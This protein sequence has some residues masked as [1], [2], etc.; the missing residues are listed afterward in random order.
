MTLALM[1]KGIREMDKD[2]KVVASGYRKIAID[3]ANDI[4]GGKYKEGQKLHGRSVLSSYYGVSP[5]T[6]RKAAFLLKDVGILD[7]ERGSGIEVKSL[8]QAKDFVNRQKEIQSMNQIM[9][10]IIRWTEAQRSEA[11]EIV[12]KLQAVADMES[13]LKRRNSFTPFEIEVSKNSPVIGKSASELNFWHIT[14]GTIVAIRREGTTFL[15]PGP[16]AVFN[17]GDIFYI[18]GNEAAYATTLKLLNG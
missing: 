9:N 10:E 1:L 16:Y 4:V 15:S 18:V 13:H 5:E 14:G 7:T 17:A 3:I 12:K 8:D 11:T 6:I 2:Q